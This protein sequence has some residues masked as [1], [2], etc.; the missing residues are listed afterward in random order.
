MLYVAMSL[1]LFFWIWKNDLCIYYGFCPS[2]LSPK[3]FLFYLPLVIIASMSLW[4][5]T[6]ARSDYRG[7]MP[8]VISVC[9]VGFLEETLYRGLLFRALE[10]DNLKTAVIVCSLSFGFGHVVNLFNGNSGKLTI[11]IQIVFAILIGI[12]LVLIVYHGGSL[13]PCI[14]FHSTNNVLSAFFVESM[15]SNTQ[16]ILKLVVFVVVLGGYLLFLLKA[17]SKTTNPDC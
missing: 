4:E 10:K 11:A 3:C 14:L 17:F 1:F 12:V 6:G 13:I 7:M 16:M 5:G 15:N 2:K 9:F 8:Y